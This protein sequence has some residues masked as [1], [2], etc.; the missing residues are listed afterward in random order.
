[1]HYGAVLARATALADAAGAAAAVC[2]RAGPRLTLAS[3]AATPFAPFATSTVNLAATEIEYLRRAR[4]CGHLKAAHRRH[5]AFVG[6]GL[7]AFAID[8]IRP[9]LPLMHAGWHLLSC[10][11][12]H[13]TL[14]LLQ[15]VNAQEGREPYS[16]A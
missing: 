13:S 6:A 4:T 16:M 1:M 14:P 5:C 9:G 2:P 10:A 15:D 3:A 11:A 12:A 8:D 7:V